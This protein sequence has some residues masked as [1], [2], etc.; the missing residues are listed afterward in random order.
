MLVII[1]VVLSGCSA[2]T[3]PSSPSPSS[4]VAASSTPT[5][6]A[7]VS[8]PDLAFGGDCASA[9]TTAQVASAVGAEVTLDAPSAF[10]DTWTVEQLGGIRCSWTDGSNH[11]LVWMTIIPT[12]AAGAQ[13]AKQNA[14]Q[15]YCYGGDVAAGQSDACSFGTVL[16]PW[17][18]AGVAYTAEGSHL[19]SVDA[20]AALTAD[21]SPRLMGEDA[22]VP[23]SHPA[24]W[25]TSLDC[26]AVAASAD[27][28]SVLADPALTGGPGN[29]GAELG[30]GVYGAQVATG[31]RSC[32]WDDGS[33]TGP[34]AFTI[35]VIPGAA[36]V[37]TQ[38][39]LVGTHAVKA[40]GASA[41]VEAM[42]PGDRVTYLYVTDGTNLL[43]LEPNT[44]VD[45]A[46]LIPVVAPVLTALAG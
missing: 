5:A 25:S 2:A 32:M 6:A 13:V 30:P 3:S 18:F 39:G 26:A 20:I 12:A 38:G 40:A 4:A 44:S 42:V 33:D 7:A 24:T 19:H 46:T 8:R 27:L 31:Y 11:Q 37:L 15:P 29:G 43:I 23:L 22:R 34:K 41:A 36:W 17:W 35:E 9:L 28:A 21:L 45:V 16:G 10:A 14:G 1:S